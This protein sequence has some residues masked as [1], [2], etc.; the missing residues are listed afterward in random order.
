VSVGIKRR[1]K[2]VTTTSRIRYTTD[3]GVASITIDCPA[4]KNALNDQGWSDLADALEQATHDPDVRVVQ[5]QGT[6]GDLCSGM[7]LEESAS[8]DHPV[9]RMRRLNQVADRLF[10]MPKPVVTTIDGVATGAGLSM[11]LSSDFVL[12]TPESKFSA[13]FVQRG[14]TPDCGAAW[15][16]VHQNSLLTAKRMAMLGEII[17]GTTA[18]ELGWVTWLH[19]ETEMQQQKESLV[20]RLLNMSPRA[21]AETK[22]LLNHAAGTTFT[23]SLK[24]EALAQTINLGTD[25]PEAFN[26]FVEGRS[27]QY[28]GKWRVEL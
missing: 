24:M 2:P 19:P 25:A 10:E 8:Q 18:K 27:P 4:K 14:L 16:L 13:I 22:A 26:A 20:N 5:L 6:G 17:D 23:D 1:D 11:A 3:G 12:A 21:L 9:D 15:L 7:D 28:D